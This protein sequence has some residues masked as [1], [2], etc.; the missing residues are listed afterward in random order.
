MP[1]CSVSPGSGDFTLCTRGNGFPAELIPRL[2]RFSFHLASHQSFSDLH[3]CCQS[4]KF[5]SC[6][7]LS[8]DDS[9][10]NCEI[11]QLIYLCH[12]ICH[13]CS[14]K[15]KGFN[16]IVRGYCTRDVYASYPESVLSP[17]RCFRLP[18]LIIVAQWSKKK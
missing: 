9:F 16:G 6:L 13:T 11:T 8:P 15:H 4:L 18:P 17:G 7:R 5:T 14:S 1:P 2:L 3:K 12:A 10:G